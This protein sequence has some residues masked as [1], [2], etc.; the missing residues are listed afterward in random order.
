MSCQGV[1]EENNAYKMLFKVSS[2]I[3]SNLSQFESPKLLHERLG[4]ASVKTM[5]TLLSTGNFKGLE[6][7]DPAKFFVKLVYSKN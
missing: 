1:T 3:E 2:K 4:H 7:K 6:K 5:N